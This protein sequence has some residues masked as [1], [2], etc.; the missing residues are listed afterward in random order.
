MSHLRIVP[1]QAGENVHA[2]VRRPMIK[3]LASLSGTSTEGQYVLTA[4]M[5]AAINTPR[6]QL[7][8]A[9]A[10]GTVLGFVWPEH[11]G[12]IALPLIGMPAKVRAKVR[13]YE[14]NAQLCVTSLSPLPAEQIDIASGLLIN[15]PEAI[16]AALRRLEVSLPPVLRMFLT[17][18]LF[19]PAIGPSFLACRASG[20]HH[21]SSKGG[22]AQHSV[23]NL[24]L[25]AATVRRTLP[26]DTA[27]VGIAQLGY[28][29]HDIG[30]I[31]TVGIARRPPLHNVVRHEIHNLL[32]L[33]PHLEWLRNQDFKLHA[34][35]VYILDYLA[36]PAA[37]RSRPRY[38]PAE[39]V[40]QFDQWSAAAFSA[41]NL[42]A[43]TEAGTRTANRQPCL[44][45]LA[46]YACAPQV[47][48]QEGKDRR[49]GRRIACRRGLADP[50]HASRM[51]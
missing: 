7:N 17:R 3:N 36:T 15:V 42:S 1:P 49:D 45:A 2:D 50:D 19:D 4:A 46:T 47:G 23:E 24:D 34:G 5:E 16:R 30:K 31:H 21:H 29:F 26:N 10:T 11:R 18:I 25:I 40:A 9:D 35:L 38:F 44:R 8:L 12:D 41:R 39:V 48:G 33:A 27:S 22:L 32:V 20:E 51:P 28:L 14:G 37:A 13:T 6:L 43:L